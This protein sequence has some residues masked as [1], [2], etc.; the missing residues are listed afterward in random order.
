MPVPKG[1]RFGGRQKGTRNKATKPVREAIAAYDPIGKLIE[2]HE[3]LYTDAREGGAADGISKK[4]RFQ[5]FNRDEFTCRYCGK[6]PPNIELEIDHV[7]PRVDGGGDE[8]ENLVTSCVDCNRGKGTDPVDGAPPD[9][10]NVVRVCTDPDLTLRTLSA[11]LPF[12]YPRLAASQI[13]MKAALMGDVEL[14]LHPP[15][16]KK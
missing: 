3:S 2:L 4:R 13:D 15:A 7:K 9:G 14:H 11:I 1:T 8:F 10:A 12:G 6:R 16:K 5:V